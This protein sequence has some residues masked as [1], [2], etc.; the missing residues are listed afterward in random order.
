MP[1]HLNV[2]KQNSYVRAGLQ[3]CHRLIGVHGFDRTKSGIF[4]D[5]DGTH[6]QHHLVLDD[7]H[8][9]HPG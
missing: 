7:K 4:H 6:A 8:V 3:N 1:W 2:G 9:G 5:I